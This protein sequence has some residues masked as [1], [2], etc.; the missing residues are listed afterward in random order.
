MSEFISVKIKRR[1]REIYTKKRRPYKK[2]EYA[3]WTW[4]DVFN[5]VE[6]ENVFSLTAIKDVA[7]KYG[8]CYNTLRTKYN[9]WKQNGNQLI[10]KEKGQWNKK[11]T[12]YDEK[13]LLRYIINVFVITGLYFDDSCLR[14]C[15]E[16]RIKTL[17]PKRNDKKISKGWV[18]YFKKKYRL[19]SLCGS[20]SKIASFKSDIEVKYYLENCDRINK[21]YKKEDI[22]NLDETFWCIS[23]CNNRVIGM[24]NSE[25]RKLIM[26]VDKKLG[27]TAVFIVSAKGEFM[28]PIIILKGKTRRGINK[29]KISEEAPVML[30]HSKNGWITTNILIKL[31]NLI[32]INSENRSCCLIMDKFSVHTNETIITEA[33][34]NNIEILFVPTG[35]TG[36]HQPLDVGVNGAIKSTGKRVMKEIYLSDPYAT[37]TIKDGIC[38]LIYS[39]IQT[40]P[41]IIINSFIKACGIL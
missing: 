25:N 5:E 3:E 26:N 21:K 18:Y 23:N 13:A 17:Y 29:L 8:I 38:A 16:E 32:K 36:E 10:I 37:P 15:A 30:E 27:F 12:D 31:L 7:L 28:I 40:Q 33:S 20:P 4:C 22:Y 41:Q 11:F 2:Y 14:F 34:R 24:T 19:S 35:R 6:K 39:Y 1:K 9:K